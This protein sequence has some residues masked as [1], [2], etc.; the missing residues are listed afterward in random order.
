M[1]LIESR[2]GVVYR[3]CDCHSGEVR[4]RTWSPD[5][6]LYALSVR[7]GKVTLMHRL[8]TDA[9]EGLMV[10][11]I[12]GD[13]TNNQCYNLRLC[14]N[15]ENQRNQR[16]HSN[17]SSGYKGVVL[18]KKSGRWQARIKVNGTYVYL[19]LY[20]D[21]LAAAAAYNRGAIKYH[22]AFARLNVI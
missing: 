17:N 13:P 6:L 14:S 3:V 1:V 8:V 22:G 7:Q 4:R 20:D 21:I 12:D 11:H 18:R 5:A 19:G 9:P 15:T 10:D 2:R 16:L